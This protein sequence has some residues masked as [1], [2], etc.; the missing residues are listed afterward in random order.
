MTKEVIDVKKLLQE[1]KAQIV[2][3]WILEKE[4]WWYKTFLSIEGKKLEDWNI[5][6]IISHLC[7]WLWFSLAC[8]RKQ[9]QNKEIK[10]N[11][12]GFNDE[13]KQCIK[14]IEKSCIDYKNAKEYIIE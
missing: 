14:H 6:N 4:D 9:V 7:E 11:E 13:V 10:M 2:S 12:K 1:W 3:V 8:L 5:V